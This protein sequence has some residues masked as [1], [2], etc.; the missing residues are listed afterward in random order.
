MRQ[1][2]VPAALDR[3]GERSSRSARH[4]AGQGF[5]PG[6][7]AADETGTGAGLGFIKNVPVRFGTSRQDYLSLFKN[8]VEKAAD[9]TK[10]E[11]VL[12]SAGFDAHTRD[13][14]GSLGL[15]TED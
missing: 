13:P 8:A 1:A 7:G 4:R 6:T 14:I 10:P 15:E 5:S 9:E 2:G 11:L 3:A 12:I